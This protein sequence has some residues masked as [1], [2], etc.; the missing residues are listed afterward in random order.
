VIKEAATSALTQG[1]EFDYAPF[2]PI[3]KNWSK[4]RTQ[5]GHALFTKQEIN[6]H[7]GQYETNWGSSSAKLTLMG[8][9]LLT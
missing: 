6:Q 5:V 2:L 1:G 9:G 4:L 7:L 8:Y 3:A